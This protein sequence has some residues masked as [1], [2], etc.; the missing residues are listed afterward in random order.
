MQ[1]VFK[2]WTFDPFLKFGTLSLGERKLKMTVAEPYE[3]AIDA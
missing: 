2:R 1:I 3:K